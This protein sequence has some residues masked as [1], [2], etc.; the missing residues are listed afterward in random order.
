MIKRGVPQASLDVMMASFAKNT[1]KQY[2]SSIKCWWYFCKTNNVDLYNADY[3]K[4]IA[5][6]TTKLNEGASY[7]SLNIHRS[8]LS[9]LLGS[10][11]TSN[12][13]INRFFKGVFRLNPPNPKYQ[14]TWDTNVVLNYL[15]NVYPYDNIALADLTYKTCALLAIASAQ[16]MQTISL[17]KLQN[18][19]IQN[20]AIVIKISDFIKTSRPG[21]Y[22]PLIRLPFIL[23][24]PS[25]C[26]AL[27]LRNYID[28]TRALRSN[29]SEGNL[30]ISTR[31]PHKTVGSQTLAHWVKHVLEK[32]GVDITLFGAHST[33]AAS[34]SAA[35]SSGVNLE[36]VRK[37]AGWS[38]TSNVFL[39]YYC[40]E[41]VH[42][43]K[44]QFVNAL[45]RNDLDE[46]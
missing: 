12:D 4:I 43:D 16:R 29:H 34:T 5:F 14:S 21:T 37:A 28:K 35:H 10:N 45:F 30:F 40:R 2:S 24:R 11:A 7:S 36:V 25:V 39:K 15:S 1:L 42:T 46:N 26:P 41:V 27:A 9:I 13:N 19:K 33:R 20:D 3:T 6:L 8:A 22:Q 32:S 31:K 18:I 44:D 17:I 23:E 38:D